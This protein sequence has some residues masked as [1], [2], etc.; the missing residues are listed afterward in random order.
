MKNLLGDQADKFS[1]D[2]SRGD[3]LL[4]SFPAPKPDPDVVKNIKNNIAN[5][6]KQNKRRRNVRRSSEVAVAAVLL[7]AATLSFVFLHQTHNNIPNNGSFANTSEWILYDDTEYSLILSEVESLESNI[8]VIR[9]DED[10]YEND[11]LIDIEMEML[12]LESAFL[13][14]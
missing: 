8:T 9:M 14:G 2:I 5:Q 3:D 13:K 11:N 4:R 7:V 6:L 10:N 1:E 12:E